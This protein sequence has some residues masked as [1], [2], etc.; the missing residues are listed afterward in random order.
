MPGNLRWSW[1]NNNRNKVHNNC[2]ALESSPNH[3]HPGSWQHYLP[4]NRFLV[5]KRLGSAALND[6][7]ICLHNPEVYMRNTPWRTRSNTIPHHI[8]IPTHRLLVPPNSFALWAVNYSCNSYL[9]SLTTPRD[10]VSVS[11][12]CHLGFNGR[13]KQV[14]IRESR[15]SLLHPCGPA[16]CPDF[17]LLP[18]LRWAT[19]TLFAS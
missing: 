4:W 12:I 6:S 3:S 15:R 10:H 13:G 17:L 16:F 14:G 2:Y 18:D 7:N 9:L 8:A 11:C 19:E 1:P 5:P